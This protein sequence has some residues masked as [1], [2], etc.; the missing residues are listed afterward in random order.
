MN[1]TPEKREALL[2]GASDYRGGGFADASSAP[3]RFA[4]RIVEIRHALIERRPIP[5]PSAEYRA[6]A[7]FAHKLF[8]APAHANRRTVSEPTTTNVDHLRRLM[9]AARIL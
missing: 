6:A 1:L 2:T 4:D 9:N 5:E 8:R 7:D 3:K